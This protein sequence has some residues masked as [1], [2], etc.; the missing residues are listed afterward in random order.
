[1]Q[2]LETVVENGPFPTVRFLGEGGEAISV[3][4]AYDNALDDVQLIAKAKVLLL[5]AATFD[6]TS[7]ADDAR[8]RS[9]PESG[10][11]AS[12]TLEY[13]DKGHVQE[14]AGLSFPTLQAVLAECRRSAA[15]RWQDARSRGEAPVGWAKDASGAVVATV[16][17]E[18][19][20]TSDADVAGVGEPTSSN[21]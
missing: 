18:D 6:E 8:M 16:D 2:I 20:R 11:D 21:S 15:D 17:Y 7:P 19:F 13:Q 4:L 10:R 12:Y 14:L 9:Q 5:H 3:S 1:M